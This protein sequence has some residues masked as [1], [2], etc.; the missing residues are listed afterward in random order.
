MLVLD[1]AL[2]NEIVYAN[3]LLSCNFIFG[4]M[5]IFIVTRINISLLALYIIESVDKAQLDCLVHF[6][7]LANRT[8]SL[9]KNLELT[10]FF[11]MCI[12]L[13]LMMNDAWP[14]M[15]FRFCTC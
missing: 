13:L 14:V 10:E 9:A 11:C 2:W 12:S 3:S 6:C 5:F 7:K 15:P 1:I 4:N 8:A